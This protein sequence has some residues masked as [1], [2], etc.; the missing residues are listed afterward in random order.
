[1]LSNLIPYL[2]AMIL[3]MVLF[4]DADGDDDDHSGGMMVPSY[5]PTQ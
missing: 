3:F 2:A 1:M 5:N 4:Q